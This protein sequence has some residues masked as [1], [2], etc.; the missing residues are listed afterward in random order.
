MRGFHLRSNEF[1]KTRLG[2]AIIWAFLLGG[3]ASASDVVINEIMYHPSH[4]AAQ[5]E[6]T[7]REWLELCNRGTNAVNLQGWR[8]SKGVEFAFTNI[9]L[10]PGGYLV[11]AASQTNFLPRYPG[12][13]NVVGDWTGRLGNTDDEIRLLDAS[14]E[15]V[16]RVAYADSGDWA[17]RARLSADGYGL[18]GWDWL[19]P[20]DGGGRTLELINPSMPNPSGQNWAASTVTDGTPGAATQAKGSGMP[21]QALSAS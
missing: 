8:L 6:D 4:T 18:R 10:P 19:A 2:A 16:N 11:V 1:M 20:Q 3:A 12:V 5:A 21:T 17:V 9:T 7:G 15:V 13:T 14:G